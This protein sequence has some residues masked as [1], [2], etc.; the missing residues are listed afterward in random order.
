MR[1]EIYQQKSAEI[2]DFICESNDRDQITRKLSTLR[3]TQGDYILLDNEESPH[4]VDCSTQ[5]YSPLT[6]RKARQIFLDCKR[7]KFLCIHSKEIVLH[8]ETWFF[9]ACDEAQTAAE[10]ETAAV[11]GV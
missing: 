8:W 5:G 7:I 4:V 2:V 10:R 9:R 1:Y 11:F 3:T 6:P